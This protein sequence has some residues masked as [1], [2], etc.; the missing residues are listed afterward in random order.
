MKKAT[1]N[2]DQPC[3]DSEVE[4]IEL[5]N[6]E[7][8]SEKK[9]SS[10][11]EDRER[12]GMIICG[13]RKY[14]EEK[15][16]CSNVESKTCTLRAKK[17]KSLTRTSLTE[18]KKCRGCDRYRKD[19]RDYEFE[20]I[21]NAAM[22]KISYLGTAKPSKNPEWCE[23]CAALEKFERTEKDIESGEKILPN[24]TRSRFANFF[25]R[26]RTVRD[27]TK[28]EHTGP[29]KYNPL[30]TG[31]DESQIGIFIRNLRILGIDETEKVISVHFYLNVVWLDELLCD[32]V[33]RKRNFK[34]DKWNVEMTPG[35]YEEV[36]KEIKNQK[37]CAARW[38]GPCSNSRKC[39][40][41][42]IWDTT[43]D[44]MD[45]R[46]NVFSLNKKWIGKGTVY[47][48]RLIRTK[49]YHSFQCGS[50]PFGYEIFKIKIRLISYTKQHLV[51]FRTKLWYEEHAKQVD[52]PFAAHSFSYIHPDASLLT[53]WTVCSVHG[54]K[55]R[56]YCKFDN[57]DLS[58]RLPVHVSHGLDTQSSFEA[59]VVLKRLPRYA[60]INIWVWFSLTSAVAL[61]TYQ[62]DPSQDLADRLA[63]AVGVIFIQMQL[64]I[65]CAAKTPRMTHITALD[66]HMCLSICMVIGQAMVQ[67]LL[68]KSR[69]L[70]EMN[71][72]AAHYNMIVFVF[73]NILIFM[74]AKCGQGCSR[75]R[76]QR[77]IENLTGF[78]NVGAEQF[79]NQ[80]SV[81]ESVKKDGEVDLE[82]SEVVRVE[83]DREVDLGTSGVFTTKLSGSNEIPTRVS[84]Y[85]RFQALKVSKHYLRNRIERH[86]LKKADTDV[87][88]CYSCR[89]CDCVRICNCLCVWI[90][91]CF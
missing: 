21:T 48:R 25:R 66:I 87:P 30:W 67:I 29:R 15:S 14:P 39:P 8:N 23:V 40:E 61:L 80:L 16:P 5:T 26:C 41:L 71:R 52:I 44:G 81:Y 31:K 74:Y 62:L 51:L 12:V 57:N 84:G 24:D 19:G 1:N 90:C 54:W 2:K 58:Y 60:L 27:M 9:S 42:K 76:I 50:Y 18:N 35:E 28:Y 49:I 17:F 47:H 38:E 82:S 64:K 77:E 78:Q 33:K 37:R 73:I 46:Q 59:M 79:E 53:D 43:T 75:K 13:S 36:W 45:E 34:G 70:D 91:K 69:V 63:I 83:N 22:P 65:Q 20:E 7:N 72:T 6:Q 4:V 3:S 56:W 11:D 89:I 85:H 86:K 68:L 32:H 55:D 10:K 88:I